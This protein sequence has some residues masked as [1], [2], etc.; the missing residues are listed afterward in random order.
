MKKF[1][2]LGLSLILLASVAGCANT[3]EEKI[4]L[5][6]YNCED[7]IDE[8]LIEAFE[9]TYN[10]N[11]NYYTY[12]TN[13]TLYNQLTLQEEGTYDLIC[14]SEYMIQ[15]LINE[16]LII[17]LDQNK[18]E[19]YNTYGIPHLIQKLNSM[20]TNK[21]DGKGNTLSLADYT[22]G[23]MWGTLGLIYDPQYISEDDIKHWDVLWDEKYHKMA[24]IKNSMRDTYVVGILHAYEE[25]LQ[26]NR[27]KYLNN[28]ITAE[29][30]NAIIQEIFNLHD[31]VNIQKVKD[32]LVSLR[33]NIYG[34]EVDSGKT[35]IITGKI[36]MNLAWSGDAVYSMK[37]AYLQEN[38]YLKYFVPEDG[39]NIWYDGWVMPKGANEDLAYKFINFISDP[40]NA[41]VNMSYIGYSSFIASEEVFD[42]VAY[43]YGATDYTDYTEYYAEYGDPKNEDEYIAPSHVFYQ[44]EFYKC[45]KDA[46]GILPTNTEYFV[47]LNE[48][49]SPLREGR[50]LSNYFKNIPN[51]R[52]TYIYPFADKA[53]RLETQYPTDEI[54]TRCAFMNDFGDDNSKVIIMWG[55]VKATT[56]MTPY[57]LI[58]IIV[59]L[60]VPTYFIIK[61][62]REKN[63]TKYATKRND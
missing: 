52:S 36:K 37:T 14:P 63:N 11:V 2:L 56:N 61:F 55:Q 47:K 60:F 7:Y 12:D 38:K 4:D 9:E 51:T 39:S 13:E 3:N 59:A 31:E 46:V 53:N 43:E 5:T 20:K 42:Y 54:I 35:D 49:N 19:T 29:Q 34:F 22:A 33:S 28:E 8:S 23:Y 21:V 57:Y 25:L 10:V 6:I 15:R 62:I 41:A 45:I 30:Y 58:L 16:D 17:P 26:E 24:S 1:T 50:D 44:N 40:A 32:E 48:Q 18:L 27:R